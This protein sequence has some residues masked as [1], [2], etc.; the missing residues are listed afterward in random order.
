MIQILEAAAKQALSHWGLDHAKVRLIKSRENHVFSIT[1]DRSRY[2]LRIHRA[3][4]HSHRG[5]MSEFDWLNALAKGGIAAPQMITSVDG[6]KAHSI[7]IGDAVHFVDLQEHIAGSPLGT[8][9]SGLSD[10]SSVART[11]AT[12]GEL[13]AKLHN[14]AETWQLPAG[15]TR[16]AFDINGL[17]GDQPVW[18]KF[19][20]N[21]NLSNHDRDTCKAFRDRAQKDLEG[22][23][24][25]PDRFGL[26]HCD[27]VAEN[28][29]KDGETLNLIDFDDCAFGWHLFDLSTPLF[30]HLGES[31]F[32]EAQS[33]LIEGYRI[34]RQLPDEHIQLLP[35]FFAARGS[36]YLGWGVSRSDVEQPPELAAQVSSVAMRLIQRYLDS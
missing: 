36:T 4:Y 24:E 6:Q 10:S 14:Q 7:M 19:W 12:I 22:F 13:A 3:N 17:V 28:L 31:Y 30:F 8:I 9:E 35:L 26:I 33:A 5:L 23:G 2:I 15:F 18:G 27:L 1:A 20:E 25:T 32:D 16:G 11:F 34:R 29:L 21:S